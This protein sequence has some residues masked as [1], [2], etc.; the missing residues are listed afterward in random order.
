[1][2][3]GATMWRGSKRQLSGSQGER[4]QRKPAPLTPWSWTTS[5]QNCEKINAC[6]LSHQVHS[7]LLGQPQHT[8]LGT[9][10]TSWF[11]KRS[12]ILS[13]QVHAVPHQTLIHANTPL[14]PVLRLPSSCSSFETREALGKSLVTPS[15][16]SSLTCQ[17]GVFFFPFAPLAPCISL[18]LWHLLSVSFSI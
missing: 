12:M 15:R 5:L 18:L 2:C 9:Y 10:W 8:K 14:V 6:C 11:F 16:K 3:R 1:M 4:G 7:T 17:M 13:L